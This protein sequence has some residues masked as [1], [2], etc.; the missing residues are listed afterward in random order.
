[1]FFSSQLKRRV[2][3]QEAELDML[4]QMLDN[5]S[6]IVMLCDTTPD[7]TIFYMNKAAREMMAR[8]RGDLNSGLRGADVANA[9]EEQTATLIAGNLEEITRNEQAQRRGK[10]KGRPAIPGGLCACGMVRRRRYQ[11]IP[12]LCTLLPMWQVKRHE[13]PS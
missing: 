6:N 13:M 2:E 4:K 11:L 12:R 3:E 9:F 7:N 1:M 5:L 8:H 10:S